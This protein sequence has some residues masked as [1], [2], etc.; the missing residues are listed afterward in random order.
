MV[1]N[2]AVVAQPQRRELVDVQGLHAVQLIQNHQTMEAQAAVGVAVDIFKAEGVRAPVRDLHGVGALSRQALVAA[3]HGPDAAH[4]RS[5]GTSAEKP[6][7]VV[8]KPKTARDMAFVSSM[9][10]S[11]FRFCPHGKTV[12][13]A[14]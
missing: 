2:L 10:D 11:N 1:V 6:P 12:C 8:Q 3:K 5:V 4:L 14:G 9:L 13:Q 7:T